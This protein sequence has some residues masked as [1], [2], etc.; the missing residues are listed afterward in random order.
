MHIYAGSLH[1]SF[2]SVPEKNRGILELLVSPFEL[3]S[4]GEKDT[5]LLLKDRLSGFSSV[6]DW[7][8]TLTLHEVS[9]KSNESEPLPSERSVPATGNS[10]LASKGSPSES[11][12]VKQNGSHIPGS[13]AAVTEERKQQALARLKQEAKE[14]ELVKTVLDVF[15]GSSIE[16]VVPVNRRTNQV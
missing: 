4:L 1:D 10:I 11:S 2:F 14:D 6:P 3:E 13:H 5:M 15:K 12:A 7:D 9:V 8:V 16:K